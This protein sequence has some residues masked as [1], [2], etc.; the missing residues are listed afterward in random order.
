ME[1]EVK[2]SKV[3][4]N[5]WLSMMFKTYNCLVGKRKKLVTIT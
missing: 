3:T 2:E 4:L 5:F 1:S